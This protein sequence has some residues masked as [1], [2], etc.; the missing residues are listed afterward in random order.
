MHQSGRDVQSHDA[1]SLAGEAAAEKSGA[2]A[3]VKHALPGDSD[4][5]AFQPPVELIGKAGAI[6]AV[7]ARGP[8]EIDLLAVFRYAIEHLSHSLRASTKNMAR[9]SASQCR[10]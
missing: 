3:E 1:A 9:L 4:A 8:A 5:E 6:A 10:L 2:R 7:I